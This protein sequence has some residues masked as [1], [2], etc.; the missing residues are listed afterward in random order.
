MARP[1]TLAARSSLGAGHGDFDKLGRP[2]PV[3]DDL[4]GKVEAHLVEGTPEFPEMRIAGLGD[5]LVLRPAGGEEQDRVAGRGVGIDGDVVEALIH[6]ALQEMLL[7]HAVGDRRIGEDERQ[8]GRHVRRDHART[9][10]DPGDGHGCAV[11]LHLTGAALGEGIGGGDGLGRR[12]PVAAEILRQPAQGRRHLS[13]L[14]GFADDAGLGDKHLIGVAA[15]GLR[16]GAGHRRDR[17]RSRLAGKRIGV[18]RIDHQPPGLSRGKRAAAPINGRRGGFRPGKDA[19]HTSVPAGSSTSSA[20]SFSRC[21][22]PHA[23]DAIRTPPTAGMSGNFSGAN[24]EICGDLSVIGSRPLKRKAPL[25]RRPP[26]NQSRDR[27]PA[28]APRR[29]LYFGS[30][31]P[32]GP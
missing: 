8:H 21:L 22:M 5:P 14:D 23:A 12:F 19:G 17:V 28:D 6:R 27:R 18:S 24:G 1:T 32:S 13:D 11:D 15:D 4:M 2:L 29:L 7:Q 20:S 3:P 25:P 26:F 16:R 31:R 9:L 10:G 30:G